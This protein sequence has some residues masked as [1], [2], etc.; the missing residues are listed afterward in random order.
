MK[1]ILVIGAGKS[2]TTLIDYLCEHASTCNW[3][4]TVADLRQE[5]AL[6]KT[7][8]RP[9]SYAIALDIT[10]EIQRKKLIS[11]H[12]II[13]SML[14][15]SMHI[16]VAGDCLEFG[17]HLVTASYVSDEMQA[18]DEEARKKGLIFLNEIGLD[19][20]LDHMSAMRVLDKLKADGAILIGFETFTGGLL[21]PES[22]ESN[23]WR[24]K[25]TWNPRNVVLAASGGAVKFLHGGMY[26]YIPY[27]KVFRR[28][29]RIELEGIGTFEGYANRDSLKYRKIYQLEGIQ[30][31]YRGTLRR[32]GFCRAWDI[33]VQLGLTDDSYIIEESEN[34]THRDFINSFLPHHPTDS[35]EIKLA[36]A[37]R[38]DLDSDEM[39]KLEWLG[40]FSDEPIGL[41][42]P[43]T[44]AQLLQH[45]LEKKWTLNEKDI[46]MIVMWHKFNYTLR[47]QEH[48]IHSTIQV[49][50]SDALNTAM[51]K[52]VGLPVAI[53][54]Q[55]ILEGKITSTG[56]KIPISK[57]IY[58]P[59]LSELEK[60]GIRCIEKQVK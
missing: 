21:A 44:P 54:T 29:E 10:N 12:D 9:G 60:N 28:T 41:G 19:P 24:Y 11:K 58:E 2:A 13:I 42:K 5:D 7:K 18:M 34:M 40:I 26:K 4:V 31:L 51:A 14:P 35:V 55:L 3:E 17:K 16:K 52:T 8:G 43:A 57:E 23:P 39:L 59:V 33:F 38:I 25:F 48:E 15:A 27:H 47:E 53:A 36:H 45:I 50:G 49:K 56:V 30:T 22:E 6:N 32:P 1:K 37:M 46:D 20:G